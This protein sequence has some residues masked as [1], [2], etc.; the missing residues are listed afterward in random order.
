MSDNFTLLVNKLQPSSKVAWTSCLGLNHLGFRKQG[1]LRVSS[2]IY[3]PAKHGERNVD[4]ITRLQLEDKIE[5]QREPERQLQR[6]LRSHRELK[7]K[8][9]KLE[10]NLRAK[11]VREDREPTSLGSE[12]LFSKDIMWAK[13]PRSFKSPDMNL[14]DGTT[15]PQHRT[16]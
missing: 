15:N 10:S 2:Q 14:F 11:R 3:I 8:L 13:V 9:K 5:R 1:G 16:T 4:E 7:E 6:E 12:D